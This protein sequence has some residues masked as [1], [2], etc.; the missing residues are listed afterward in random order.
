MAFDTYVSDETVLNF[1][2]HTLYIGIY[3]RNFNH[4]KFVFG[5]QYSFESKPFVNPLAAF[6]FIIP[7]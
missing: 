7:I 6:T 5:R 2:I 4:I 1:I 3:F